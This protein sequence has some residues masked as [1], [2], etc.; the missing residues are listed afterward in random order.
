MELSDPYVNL[1]EIKKEVNYAL[2][3]F[4]EHNFTILDVTSR[5]IEEAATAIME[6]IGKKGRS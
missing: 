3:L 2:T 5:S 6:I 4:R 1:D